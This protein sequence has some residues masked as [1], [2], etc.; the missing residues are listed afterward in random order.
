MRPE[1]HWF[2]GYVELRVS[3]WPISN[4]CAVYKASMTSSLMSPPHLKDRM[5]MRWLGACVSSMRWL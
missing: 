5:E 4:M 1:Y 2:I 3:V